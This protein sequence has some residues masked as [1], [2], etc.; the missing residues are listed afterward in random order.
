MFRLSV[1]KRKSVSAGGRFAARLGANES[2]FGTSPKA[3]RAMKEAAAGQ[4]MYA[5]PESHDLRHA[6]ACHHGIG[7]DNNV[8]GEG[9]DGLL[10]LAVRMCADPGSPVVTSD[11]AYPTFNFHVGA[12]GARL[13]KVPFRDD[14]EDLG[15]LLDTAK[16]E[17]ARDPLCFQ[18][19]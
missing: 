1:P 9:I 7:A 17:G 19:E 12:Q 13:I 8:I 6:L 2:L 15:Q 4:W 5:D 10:G 11:G 18:S 16:R 3:I 14:K